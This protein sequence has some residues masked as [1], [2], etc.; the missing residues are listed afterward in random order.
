MGSLEYAMPGHGG[1][2][3]ILLRGAKE[4]YQCAGRNVDPGLE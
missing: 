4:L 1:S 3:D 2:A